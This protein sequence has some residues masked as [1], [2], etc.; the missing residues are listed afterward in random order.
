[1][2]PRQEIR[3]DHL[4]TV[5]SSEPCLRT[6]ESQHGR[7]AS[8]TVRSRRKFV[9][10][11]GRKHG[12]LYGR[13]DPASLDKQIHKLDVAVERAADEHPQAWRLMT[14]PGVGPISSL[15]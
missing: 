5:P 11:A 4:Q 9:T 10:S 2:R 13:N 12:S 6:G 15:A 14:Q 7:S 1:M 3:A 8:V